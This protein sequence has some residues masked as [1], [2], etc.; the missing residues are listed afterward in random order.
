[1]DGDYR[2]VIPAIAIWIMWFKLIYFFKLTKSTAFFTTLVFNTIYDIIYFMI[3]FIAI[4]CPFA[5]F[6]YVINQAKRDIY[7]ENSTLYPRAFE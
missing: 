2:L 1:M 3:I 4:L 7:D 5:A 6:L